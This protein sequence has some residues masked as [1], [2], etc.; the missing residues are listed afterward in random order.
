ML[1]A[2]LVVNMGATDVSLYYLI[3]IKLYSGSSRM[4]QKMILRSRLKRRKAVLN[5]YHTPFC[6]CIFMPNVNLEG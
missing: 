1:W 5:D 2:K 6:P 3:Y 4:C